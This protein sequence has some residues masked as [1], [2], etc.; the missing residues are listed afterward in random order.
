MKKYPVIFVICLIILAAAGCQNKNGAK[1]TGQP[2]PTESVLPGSTTSPT[3]NPTTEVTPGVT[4]T[5]EVT[6]E[7]TPTPEPD[8]EPEAVKIEADGFTLEYRP[9]KPD[10]NDITNDSRLVSFLKA[11]Y[12]NADG[13]EVSFHSSNYKWDNKDRWEGSN[14][15]SYQDRFNN[16]RVSM[17]E[18]LLDS[19]SF[20]EYG[21]L[22]VFLHRADG[23]LSDNNYEAQSITVD[24]W[25]IDKD[26]QKVYGVLYQK[27][28]SATE[29]WMFE[30]FYSNGIQGEGL[31]GSVYDEKLTKHVFSSCT[32]YKGTGRD[33]NNKMTYAKIRGFYRD[34]DADKAGQY[35]IAVETTDLK[36]GPVKIYN[37]KA[38]N[39]SAKD[40]QPP[41]TPYYSYFYRGNGENWI[42]LNHMLSDI[43]ESYHAL[44]AGLNPL[45]GDF[46]SNMK[47]NIYTDRKAIGDGIVLIA[48]T[49]GEI[50]EDSYTINT[51]MEFSGT[52]LLLD[53]AVVD[54][55]TFIENQNQKVGIAYYQAYNTS[56][57]VLTVRKYNEQNEITEV[58]SSPL[59]LN[60]NKSKFAANAK[61]YLTE[62]KNT[63]NKNPGKD[64]SRLAAKSNLIYQAE[65]EG[66]IKLY[67]Y[68]DAVFGNVPP[69][70]G[71]GTIYGYEVSYYFVIPND[72][73]VY[74]LL[75]QYNVTTGKITKEQ[76]N[77]YQLK[78]YFIGTNQ[79]GSLCI[80]DAFQEIDTNLQ[81]GTEE[82]FFCA[83]IRRG[84]NGI[85][86]VDE[87]YSWDDYFCSFMSCFLPDGTRIIDQYDTWEIA[88]D[89]FVSIGGFITKAD[90]SV[91]FEEAHKA[92]TSGIQWIVDGKAVTAQDLPEQGLDKVLKEIPLGDS[93]GLSV[94][95]YDWGFIYLKVYL[96]FNKEDGRCVFYDLYEY[97]IFKDEFN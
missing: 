3:V 46:G 67:V 38:A 70:T 64:G 42:V 91:I 77:F 1:A 60:E 19:F 48:E 84:K 71:N 47:D 12:K 89:Y 78:H 40:D 33:A 49:A 43:I 2:A 41:S 44:D 53:S 4:P 24:F 68:E 28:S 18:E 74:G 22:D 14:F 27:N 56:D 76:Y 36:K 93:Y 6:P 97:R 79:D 59:Y 39:S 85:G 62:L 23:T 17:T 13:Q 69:R 75:Y 8:S 25:Y 37:G 26:L 29:K 88:T 90:G 45:I 50:A 57:S 65:F 10:K 73:I 34:S 96:K 92:N 21:R 87:N 5:D 16:C 55:V 51:Y 7:P 15:F 20:G 30:P 80:A 72:R 86:I 54:P 81:P 58:F 11:S 35:L 82:A 94:N 66:E 31:V 63:Y 32:A 9:A 52:R 83:E 61:S 95:L